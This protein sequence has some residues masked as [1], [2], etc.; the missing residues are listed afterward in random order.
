MAL[1]DHFANAIGF[2]SKVNILYFNELPDHHPT[3]A[4]TDSSD[5]PHKFP[6]TRRWMP[7]LG[8]CRGIAARDIR[9]IP[10]GEAGTVPPAP[11]QASPK[12]ARASATAIRQAEAAEREGF[13]T[14]SA[15]SS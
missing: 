5:L 8:S 9:A 7:H 12:T 10:K 11:H 4:V 13:V 6:P 14:I 15:G 3:W 1:F 2:C